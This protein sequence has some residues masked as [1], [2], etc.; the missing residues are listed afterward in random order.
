LKNNQLPPL[1]LAN[2]NFLGPVPDELKNLTVIEE[3]MI[4][5]CRSKCWII[6]LKEENQDPVLQATQCG[7]KGHIIIH[8]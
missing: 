7:M 1:F 4:A 2:R 8:L 3:A 5:L 6:R